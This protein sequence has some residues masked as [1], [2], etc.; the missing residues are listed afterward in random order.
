[1]RY[2]IGET[3]GFFVDVGNSTL[4][5]YFFCLGIFFFGGDRPVML[6]YG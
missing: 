2:E 3:E 5:L 4:C 1:M 6:G